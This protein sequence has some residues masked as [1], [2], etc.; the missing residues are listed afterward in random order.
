MRVLSLVALAAL[1]TA[2]KGDDPSTT[3]T[4]TDTDVPDTTDTGPT[5]P[6]RTDHGPIAQGIYAPQGSVVPFAT[7]AQRD[8]FERGLSVGTRRF[9]LDE[10]LGPAFNLTF[11]L[12]CHEKPH[13]GG[14]AG[15]YRNFFL[16]EGRTPEGDALDTTNA[17]QPVG[18]VI[19]MYYYGDKYDARPHIDPS[20]SVVATRNP[21]PFF[22]TGLIASLDEAVILANADEFDEDGDGISGRPN[23]REGFLGRFGVKAQT[24]SIEGFIRGPLMTHLG[25]TS[26]P[27]TEEERA[28]LPVDSSGG[29]LDTTETESA[30]L[31]LRSS[32]A[33]LAQATAPNGPLTDWCVD[34]D[35][36]GIVASGACDDVP[37]P[38]LSTSDLFDL[39]SFS[40]LLAVPEPE[41]LTEQSRRGLQRFDEARCGACHIPRLEHE[42]GPLP[43]Y[44]DLLLHD[45]GPELADGLSPGVSTGSEFRTQPLWGISSTG[46]Y[47]HDGRASTLE[48]AILAHGGEARRSRQVFESFDEG[49]RADLVEFLM[50]LGGRDTFSPGLVPPDEAVA[51]VGA[52][53][54]PRR[55]LSA[56]EEARFVA[57]RTLFD[58]EFGHEQGAG[59]PR[60]NGDSCRA[61]H[62]EP[63]V[64]G[65]GPR[66]V[67]VTRHGILNSHGE[68]TPPAVGTVLH[69]T[70][71]L[72]ENP[73]LPQ[74]EANIFEHRQTPH[75]FGLGEIE[76]I[77]DDTLLALADPDDTL[78]PDGISGRISWVDGE[79][80]GR[81]G[82]KA[83]VPS[84]DEF[85]RDAVTVELGMTLPYVEGMTYG[86]IQDNDAVP[87]PEFALEDADILADYLREL[88]PPPRQVPADQAQAD[89]GELVFTEVGCA[90]CHVPELDGV[91][92]Y[93]DLLLHEILPPDAVGIEEFSANMW[94]FRTT[95]LWGVSQT[96]PYLHSGVADT[97]WQAIEG[98]DGEAV[99]VRDAFLALP[100]DEA[101][102]L[103][104]FLETL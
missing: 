74:P 15:L 87:D 8:T 12:G 2:C 1:F 3:P 84:I 5:T 67:N 18:G 103:I 41:P 32:L 39:V 76:T 75:L 34:P 42:R 7:D 16:T 52:Y 69:R 53:G 57:G 25:V 61:C 88:A 44:S 55:A 72:A 77:A 37:D 60:M 31:W 89:L 40:M 49:E 79:Q 63:V 78:T 90:L 95:P 28:E 10:G 62:F 35:D 91:P 33:G 73:N 50:S 9:R 99:E 19:R 70:T 85:I 17:G 14:A 27:L 82:H 54:G 66:G 98:H 94:E 71:T 23:Y 13:F 97:L 86:K 26:D 96:A 56:A 48:T 58:F 68:F 92:L 104:A 80:I 36:P 65:A 93:S 59:N 46:P 6:N 47:L 29:G 4:G 64:G 45:M 22:G 24:E 38:E 81:F 51:P 30:L 20:A 100:T 21:I 83:Q 101:E 43:L 102:A 11:C